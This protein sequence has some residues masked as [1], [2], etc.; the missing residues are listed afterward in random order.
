M[1]SKD[2]RVW[3]VNM[4]RQLSAFISATT[5]HAYCTW[6]TVRVIVEIPGP[7]EGN[8]KEL[9]RLHDICSQ[10]LRALKRMGYDPSGHFVTS[11]IEMKLDRSTMFE[12]QR[13]TQENTDVPPLHGDPGVHRLRVRASETVLREAPKR[14]SQTMHSEASGP[15]QD[16]LCGERRY[17]LHI[18]RCWEAPLVCVQEN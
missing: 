5:S 6:R 11:L 9:L 1:S 17:S 7:K 8:G 13:H 10:H 14:H 12:W 4:K 2:S 3:V 15:G 18:V 16:G